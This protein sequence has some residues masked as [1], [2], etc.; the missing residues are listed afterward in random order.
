[1]TD[2]LIGGRYRVTDNLVGS[3]GFGRV[4]KARD[5][6][7][8]V[9]VAIKEVLLPPSATQAEH[10]E[11]V[12]R[13]EREARNAAKLR[14]HPNIVAVHDVVVEDG[15]P[16]LVMRFVAGI[17]LAEHLR[18]NGPLSVDEAA[19][20]ATSMLSALS[21]A[22]AAGIVHRDV[23]PANI[24]LADGRALLTDF[25]IAVHVTD[26]KLTGTG[27]FIGS[28]EYM[29]PE[30]FDG[31]ADAKS[32]L[33]ALGVTLYEAVEGT[34]PFRRDSTTGTFSAVLRG[35]APPPSRA[36][37]LTPLI[38]ALMSREARDRPDVEAARA[39]L[40]KEPVTEVIADRGNDER[41]K[42]INKQP[43][44]DTKKQQ[45]K[46]PIPVAAAVF[47]VVVAIAGI[48]YFTNKD[49]SENVASGDTASE[50]TTTTTTTEE[51]IPPVYETE[52]ETYTETETETE[53]DTE[54]E[55]V[56]LDDLPDPC[57]APDYD[58]IDL[59][60][61]R[62]P[63]P[64]SDDNSRACH[65]YTVDDGVT[66]SYSLMTLN[67]LIGDPTEV[68]EGEPADLPG[69]DAIRQDNGDTCLVAWPTSFG[70]AFAIAVG[71]GQ[72]GA[73]T[74]CEEVELWAYKVFDN[75]PS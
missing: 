15:L 12:A 72:S 66:R 2:R 25:G 19:D 43:L 58:T 5:E 21:H 14:D 64:Q 65:W 28:L 4:W 20:V 8:A 18:S 48:I 11:R 9:D 61:L 57:D 51:Y 38:T 40:A 59:F 6:R 50:L 24:M 55:T 26:T 16:L 70:H 67:Y 60:G 47:W 7:L 22:H 54:T 63:E 36:G 69:V 33:Y 13:A 71:N 32:D 52:T 46:P 53:T 56:S 30:R 62:D 35:D 37:R 75:V 44:E 42:Q 23:K 68:V 34:S 41:T 73:L 3:G 10:A 31:T 74:L 49:D 29:A 17:T 45:A 1:M 27:G 39:L